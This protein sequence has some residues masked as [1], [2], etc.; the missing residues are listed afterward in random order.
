MGVLQSVGRPSPAH[1]LADWLTFLQAPEQVIGRRQDRDRVPDLQRAGQQRHARSECLQQL[2]SRRLDAAPAVPV[3]RQPPDIRPHHQVDRPRPA[4]F[5][6][7]LPQAIAVILNTPA[8]FTGIRSSERTSTTRPLPSARRAKKSGAC[9]RSRPSSSC[10]CSQNGWEA[11]PVMSGSKSIAITWSRSSHDS[12]P[13]WSPVVD[14]HHE[15]GKCEAPF[16]HWNDRTGSAF[17]NRSVTHAA[18][19]SRCWVPSAPVNSRKNR[20]P[21]SGS[22]FNAATAPPRHQRS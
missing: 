14:D 16:A 19:D 1:R 7:G 11:I 20:T 18:S 10:Q 6:A 9:R 21:A 2:S 17:S 22:R 13:T 5:P 3:S 4:E 15:P 12:K 8:S